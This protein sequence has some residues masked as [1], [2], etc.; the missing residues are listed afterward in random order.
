M[1]T[2]GGS[3]MLVDPHNRREGQ[4]VVASLVASV[5]IHAAAFGLVPR[6]ATDPEGPPAPLSVLL[7]AAP[8]L[9]AAPEEQPAVHHPAEGTLPAMPREQRAPPR[10]QRIAQ[11]HGEAAIQ[12]HR[13]A[14]LAVVPATRSTFRRA[15]TSD[16]APAAVPAHD[17][18]SAESRA[19][20]APTEVSLAS[21][22]DVSADAVIPPAFHAEYL[23]NPAPSYPLRAR[24]DG[25]EGTVML[26]VLVTAAGA[27]GRVELAASSGSDALDRAAEDAVRS[28]RFV[29]ARRGA[30][31]IDAWVVVP[32]VFHLESG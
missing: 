5:A 15:E 31:A 19:Q 28:W 22:R 21:A 14:A 6:I 10:K 29:P 17:E 3:N 25:V 8:P 1:G 7:R 2:M 27:P 13:K 18:R 11:S 23:R 4:L 9:P 12:A 26:K 20:T 32:V 30:A 24:R 16:A